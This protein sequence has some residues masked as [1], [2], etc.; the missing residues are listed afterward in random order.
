MAEARRGSWERAVERPLGL[1]AVVFLG[2]YAWPILDPDLS[3]G[4]LTAGRTVNVVVWIAFAVDLM[5]RLVLAERRA[6]FLRSAWLDVLTLALPMLRPLRA[7]RAEA[8]PFRLRAQGRY[9]ALAD[10]LRT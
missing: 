9:V 6:R 2:A 10:R 3:D 8:G 5:V 4:L 7:L 1:A